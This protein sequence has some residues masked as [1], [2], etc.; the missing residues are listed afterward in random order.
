MWLYPNFA[1]IIN[2]YKLRQISLTTTRNVQWFG[3]FTW[4][5]YSWRYVWRAIVKVW[6]NFE[7]YKLYIKFGSNHVTVRI[8]YSRFF[9]IFNRFENKLDKKWSGNLFD[10]FHYLFNML[11]NLNRSFCHL[12]C[13]VILAKDLPRELKIHN[14]KHY[15]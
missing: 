3:H 4:I 10:F 8:I 13:M 15:Y 14:F 2:L 6:C 12:S 7:I 1:Y 11:V 5:R 9:I